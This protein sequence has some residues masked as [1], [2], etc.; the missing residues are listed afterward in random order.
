MIENS[1]PEFEILNCLYF[2]EPFSRI[3][4]ET[5][6]DRN[7]AADVL[8]DLIAR[9]LVSPMRFDDDAK[10]YV[11]SYIYDGDHMDDYHYLATKEGL[12]L[13]NGRA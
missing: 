2:V 4:E 11:R 9:K 6:I 8:K 12:L 7:I 3:L 1:D 13:H 5:G 10:E